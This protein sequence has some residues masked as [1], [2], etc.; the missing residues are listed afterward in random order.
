MKL[1]TGCALLLVLVL[2]LASGGGSRSSGEGVPEESTMGRFAIVAYTPKPGKE[3]QLLVAVRKHLMVL[4]AEQL[5]T[6]KPAHVM[7]ARDGS[8]VEV[9]EWRSAKAVQDAHSNPTVQAL[10]AEFGAACDYTPVSKLAEA[11]EMFAE[12]EAVEL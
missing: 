8:I 3:Q 5:V 7:R 6:A 9:F 10:W 1:H 12:F 4:R 2:A 11:Q